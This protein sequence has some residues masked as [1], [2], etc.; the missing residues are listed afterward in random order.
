MHMKKE[1]RCIYSE[2]SSISG[3]KIGAAGFSECLNF[4]TVREKKWKSDTFRV[5]YDVVKIIANILNDGTNK[6]FQIMVQVIVWNAEFVCLFVCV[7]A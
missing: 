2:V 7:E 5:E 3:G 4:F 6:P 1:N